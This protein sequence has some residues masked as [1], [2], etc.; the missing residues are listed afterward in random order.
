[1]DEIISISLGKCGSRIASL[2][3]EMIAAE[4]GLGRDGRYV[5][6]NPAQLERIDTFFRRSADGRFQARCVFADLEPG[7]LELVKVSEAAGLCD[8]GNFVNAQASADNNW[9][10]GYYSEG[11]EL[12]HSVLN[13]V[14]RELDRAVHPQGFLLFHA[15]GGGTGSGMGSL[16]IDRIREEF[17]DL[18]FVTVSMWPSRQESSANTAYNTILGARKLI[19]QADLTFNVEYEALY[20]GCRSQLKIFSPTHFDFNP[21]IASAVSNLTAPLRFAAGEQEFA[22]L[23]D[24]VV[25]LA[26][27]P[28]MHFLTLGLSPLIRRTVAPPVPSTTDMAQAIFATPNNLTTDPK[29]GKILTAHAVFRGRMTRPELDAA[30]RTT[31][32]GQKA[33]L[34]DW[35]PHNVKWGRYAD[36]AKGTPTSAV[37][38]A[39]TTSMQNLFKRAL[40]QY[41]DF[42]RRGVLLSSYTREGM[43]QSEFTEA[44]DCVDSLIADYQRCQDAAALA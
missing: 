11:Q 21:L 31:L 30:M 40:G 15:L 37:L 3:L 25:A 34:V 29:S 12:I 19:T 17:P 36:G 18:P 24:M 6:D 27:F 5:G 42:L 38:I 43:E 2:F 44:E 35:I 4:H 28:R 26:P 7:P 41:S 14:R 23:R 16:L 8:P 39:N 33:N 13:L 32:A 22:T 1:M 20:E 9:A 10:K